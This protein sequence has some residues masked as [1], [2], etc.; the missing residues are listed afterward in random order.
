MSAMWDP[1]D[2]GLVALKAA[3]D[4]RAQRAVRVTFADSTKWL[5]NGYV[6]CTNA[7]T[8]AGQQL[9]KTPLTM[10]VNGR[11]TTYAT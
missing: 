5:F 9:V 2:A 4:A 3:S 11:T 7:P 1:A 10:K 8:G 6:G